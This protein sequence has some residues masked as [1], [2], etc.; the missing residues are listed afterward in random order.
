MNASLPSAGGAAETSIVL[1]A[2]DRLP[3]LRKA[4]E[5]IFAQTYTDWQLIIVDD[6]SAPP[7][8]DWLAQLHDSRI[9]VVRRA[10]CG[11]PGS[12]R[13]SGL[14]LARSRYVA[15]MD[16]DDAWLAPRLERQLELMRR[17]PRRRWSYCTTRLVDANDSGL[18]AGRFQVFAPLDGDIVEA[19]LRRKA[20]V[21]TASVIVERSLL[22]ETGG[23]D[24]RLRFAEHYELWLRLALRSEVSVLN[25]PL[26]CI[27][28]HDDHY[29]ADRVAAQAGWVAFYR[30]TRALL[31]AHLRATCRELCAIAQLDL[32]RAQFV[33]A[34]PT[35]ALKSML[36]ALRCGWSRPGWWSH[37]WRR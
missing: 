7:T 16:S 26:V 17:E 6:G 18:P 1:A 24:E 32:A 5:S 10:H 36:G 14:A 30:N 19:L 22:E 11:N 29:T 28:R 2:Y 25:E 21:A 15:F 31:P 12:V 35:T 33:H 3:L 9:T 8:R 27:R 37:L 13:N 4:V 23:F 34:D 20:S